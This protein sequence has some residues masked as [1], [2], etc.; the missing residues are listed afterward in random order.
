MPVEKLPLVVAALLEAK[1]TQMIAAGEL[2]A[3]KRL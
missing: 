3:Y 2:S 1:A